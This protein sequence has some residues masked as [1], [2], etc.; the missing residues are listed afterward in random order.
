MTTGKVQACWKWHERCSHVSSKT[1]YSRVIT[2]MITSYI[3]TESQCWILEGVRVYGY[4]LRNQTA[5]EEV[6]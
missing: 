6:S 1:G 2:G 5:G 3:M 4:D